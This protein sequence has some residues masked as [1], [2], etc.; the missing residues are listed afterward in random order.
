MQTEP[1]FLDTKPIVLDKTA[2]PTKRLSDLVENWQRE[3]SHEI[4]R[5]LP[6]LSDY[7]VDV[8]LDRMDEQQG[9][10]FGSAD[11]RSKTLRSV[12]EGGPSPVSGLR[13]ARI[14]VIIKAREMFPLDVFLVDSKAFPLTEDRFR[15]H[16][17]RSE[18]FDALSDPGR[19]P[20]LIPQLYPPYRSRYGFGGAYEVKQGELVST[21][22]GTV[23]DDIRAEVRNELE[24]SASL[25]ELLKVNGGLR[26]LAPLLVEKIASVDDRNESVRSRIKP[27]VI[28][29]SKTAGGDYRLK[30]ANPGAFDPQEEMVDPATAESL[31]GKDLITRTDKDGSVTITADPAVRQTIRTDKFEVIDDFGEWKVET[32][33]GRQLMGWVFP[34]S[35]DFDMTSTPLAVFTNGSEHGVQDYIAGSRVGQGTNFPVSKPSGHGVFVHS[36]GGR[37]LCT[38][39]VTVRNTT[40]GTDGRTWYDC[41]DVM[42]N[43]VLIS[44][45]DGLRK[46]TKSGDGYLLPKTFRFMPLGGAKVDLNPDPSGIKQAQLSVF[47]PHR[48]E[49]RSDGNQWSL[50]GGCGLSKTASS[51]LTKADAEF[52]LV[53]AG[54]SPSFASEKLAEAAKEAHPVVVHGS[55]EIKLF[56]EHVKE[57]AESVASLNMPDL[58]QDTLKIAALINDPSAVDTLLALN[59]VNEENVASF[60]NALPVLEDTQ[61]KLS[62]MLMASRL[63]LQEIPLVAVEQAIRATEKVIVGLKSLQGDM[64]R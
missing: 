48:V 23:P 6:F 58:R 35:L 21:I 5:Q 19:D 18:T 2:A 11:V 33:D 50:S 64:G 57:A 14:P 13:T 30:M 39:P 28:Q 34:T 27:T 59:F 17:H 42:D 24:K 60:L 61:Q 62:E 32:L 54:L 16:M 7:E 38:V 10:A 49:I 45:A 1:L 55:N 53:S 9:Y 37:A 41:T 43:R 31:A 46:M 25:V 8:H 22:K 4:Y 51:F 52:L 26:S 20:S 44:Y 40:T 36:E 12:P 3:V 56:E 47:S 29:I 63:G 15:A